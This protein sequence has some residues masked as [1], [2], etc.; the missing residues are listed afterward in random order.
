MKDH[1]FKAKYS[2]NIFLHD[3][4]LSRKLNDGAVSNGVGLT[5]LMYGR[6]HW[7]STGGFRLQGFSACYIS[8][9]RIQFKCCFFLS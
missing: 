2:I 9:L 6:A 4:G 1:S 5:L 7:G 8:V 3:G